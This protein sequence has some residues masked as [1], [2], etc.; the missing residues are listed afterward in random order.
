MQQRLLY[1]CQS[2]QS[3]ECV[4]AVT[5]RLEKMGIA[6]HQ[7]TAGAERQVDHASSL[8]AALGRKVCIIP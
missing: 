6:G 4:K 5:E 3:Y 1:F 8:M 7:T 2:N